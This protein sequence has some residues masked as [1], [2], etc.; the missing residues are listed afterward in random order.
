MP[1]TFQEADRAFRGNRIRELY[2][3]PDGLR[4]LKLRSM[5]RKEYMLRLVEESGV[6][7]DAPPRELLRFLFESRIDIRQIERTIINIF[8][9]ERGQR[10]ERENELIT[11]L[12]R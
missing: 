11:E 3:D 12:Y 5:S 6:H 4:F 7:I 8:R 2:T 1:F 10:R 9:E